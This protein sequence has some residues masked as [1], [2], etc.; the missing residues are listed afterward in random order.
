M[1]YI[2]YNNKG[3][4]CTGSLTSNVAKSAVANVGVPSTD[5]TTG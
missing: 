3:F 1:K 2:L 4:M 5:V